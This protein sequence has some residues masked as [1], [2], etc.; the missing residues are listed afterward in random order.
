MNLDIILSSVILN[1]LHPDLG[2]SY[3]RIS[4]KQS[5]QSNQI[6]DNAI[7]E[8]DAI[9]DKIPAVTII[10]DLEG[11]VVWMSERGLERFGITLAEMTQLTAEEYYRTYFN[12]DDAKDYVPKILGL[13]ERNDDNGIC[14]FFQQV[15]FE[16]QGAWSWYL[17]STKIL[18]HDSNGK[19]LLTLT[20]AFP[21]EDMHHVTKKA[22]R[23]LEENNFLR[24]NYHLFS[25]LSIRE[26]EV[27]KYWAQSKSASETAELMY[28]SSL[29]VDTHRR[30]IKVKLQ[31]TSFYELS[32]YARCFELI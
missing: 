1:K 21:I 26:R 9:A 16:P 28:I 10:H 12:E 19:P 15:R 3:I 11:R 5:M 13:L 23:I 27:L 30:N 17:S 4:I 20:T 22:E 32:H 8:I 2:M 24:Q 25:K 31:T 7:K 14:T 29:T 18:A 6:I